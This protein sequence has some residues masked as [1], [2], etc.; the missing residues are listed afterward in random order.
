MLINIKVYNKF[1]EIQNNVVSFMR[2]EDF[3]IDFV[4]P[5][6][7]VAKKWDVRYKI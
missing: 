2:F 5:K 7:N 1:I 6:E 3:F 4:S